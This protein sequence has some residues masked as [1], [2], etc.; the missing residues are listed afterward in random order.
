M[1]SRKRDQER[2]KTG[3]LNQRSAWAPKLKKLETG[4]HGNQTVGELKKK[5]K[6]EIKGLDNSETG[7]QGGEGR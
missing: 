4:R 3:N 2:T 6:T 7:V 5:K 1:I